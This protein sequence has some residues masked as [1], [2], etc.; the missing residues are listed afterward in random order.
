MMHIALV[1]DDPIL[2]D[3]VAR[4]LRSQKFRV[5]EANSFQGLMDCMTA[6]PVDLVILDINLPGKC[7]LGICAEIRK[8]HP[9][10]TIFILSARRSLDDR[11]KGFDCG[12][13]LYLSKPVDPNELAAAVKG[14]H[15]RLEAQSVSTAWRFDRLNSLLNIPG[16]QIALSLTESQII[17]SFA[18]SADLYLR[19][20][21]LCEHLALSDERDP[22]TRRALENILSRF[23]KKLIDHGVP[24]DQPII[25]SDRNNG[26]RLCV[27]VSI[28]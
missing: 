24:A 17:T 25:Q 13:D 2:R 22:M 3:E 12:A 6:S 1:E 9:N 26:Y 28:E 18:L 4:F 8:T 11:I 7:G 23:R 5:T 16:K 10:L 19:A 14:V 20:D 27:Q 15:R 21:W